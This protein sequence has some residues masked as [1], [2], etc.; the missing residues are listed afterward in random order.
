MTGLAVIDR[1][2]LKHAALEMGTSVA[3]GIGFVG[4]L[5]R[6]PTHSQV[7]PDQWPEWL[8]TRWHAGN[9]T[10]IM[11]S[12]QWLRACRAVGSR[13]ETRQH[14]TQLS[15]RAVGLNFRAASCCF[16]RQRLSTSVAFM[17]FISRSVTAE[18]ETHYRGIT[19]LFSWFVP[20]PAVIT[21]VTAAL[22]R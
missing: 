18:S 13:A 5:L 9:V 4:F 15:F 11:Q 17:T 10:A 12:C 6:A 19:A 16:I 2:N 8:T 20:I 21:A 7:R 14:K 3:E 22:P 1:I